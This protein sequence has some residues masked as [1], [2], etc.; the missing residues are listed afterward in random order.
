MDSA[1]AT[2]D[3]ALVYLPDCIAAIVADAQPGGATGGHHIES[4]R[5]P[6]L[7]PPLYGD[8][9]RLS[10]ALAHLVS[11]AVKFTPAGRRGGDRRASGPGRQV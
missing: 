1:A 2:E 3:D 4:R 5:F 6:N 11:N 9:K 10:K 8:S 7:L